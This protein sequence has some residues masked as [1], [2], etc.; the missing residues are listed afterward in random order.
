MKKSIHRRIALS[1]IIL[2]LSVSAQGEKGDTSEATGENKEGASILL[3]DNMEKNKN[4]FGGRCS[5]Y[6]WAPSRALFSKAPGMGKSGKG[7]KVRYDKKGEGGLYGN[8]GW[9]GYYTLVHVGKKYVD[10]TPYA[11]LTFWVKGEKGGEN[12]KVGVA[13]QQGEMIDDSTKSDSINAYLPAGKV[14][15]EWQKA[16]VSLDDVFVDWEL[17]HSISFCFE[18]DLYEEGAQSG[19]IYIDDLQLEK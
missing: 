8:G 10:A 17:L 13:D 12:F 18:T 16:E 19:T 14:T 2:P 7:L 4:A 11:K 9:C 3:I 1:A 6:Q 15:T 5:V